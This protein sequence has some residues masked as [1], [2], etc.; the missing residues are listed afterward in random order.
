MDLGQLPCAHHH[1]IREANRRGVRRRQGPG[2]ACGIQRRCDIDPNTDS[3]DPTSN[4]QPYSDDPAD[5]D[6]HADL[7]CRNG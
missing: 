3:N 7:G 2:F 4:S 6:A 1:R 5:T